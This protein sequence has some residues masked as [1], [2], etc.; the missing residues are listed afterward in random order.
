VIAGRH[1]VEGACCD[2]LL[3]RRVYVHMYRWLKQHT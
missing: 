2:Q 3:Y 1:L